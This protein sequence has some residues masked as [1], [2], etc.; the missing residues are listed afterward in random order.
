MT[1]MLS[2]S[3]KPDQQV[4]QPIGVIVEPKTQLGNGLEEDEEKKQ[5]AWDEEQCVT[6][7][8]FEPSTLPCRGAKEM[9]DEEQAGSVRL[10][11]EGILEKKATEEDRGSLDS[12]SVHVGQE[13]RTESER[14]LGLKQRVPSD[15][16]QEKER[17]LGMDNREVGDTDSLRNSMPEKTA[18]VFHPNV[19]VLQLSRQR[20][21]Q[22]DGCPL[23]ADERGCHAHHGSQGAL[24]YSCYY[25]REDKP[26][27]CYSSGVRSSLKATAAMIMGALIFP[28]LVWGGY[29]F[30]PFDAPLLNTA[31]ERLV[32][33]LRCS[34]FALVPIVMGVLVL[35]VSRLRFCYVEPMYEGQV[36]PR[37]VAVHRHYI[38]DSISLFLLYF[39]QLA[40]MATYLSQK[41]LKLVPLLTIMFSL[42]RLVYWLLAALGGNGARGIGFGMSFL[43]VLA[44]L[45]ANLYFIFTL[46]A[47]GSIFAVEPLP[48]SA[49][50]PRQRFW[51]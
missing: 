16:W 51:G 26:S 23:L 27:M 8:R 36:E 14:E 7:A 24:S 6:S 28:V 5:E 37:V 21:T 15:G 49:E 22:G 29:V 3:S 38:H 45:G 34:V 41:C 47:G 46:E 17:K 19:T 31:P 43:P 13:S 32:Y 50:A 33:T 10:G 40:V 48:E 35:G 2:V 18:Q 1:E 9:A 30:L 25:D 44:M 4:P 12:G 42:G 11:K 39:L 20:H